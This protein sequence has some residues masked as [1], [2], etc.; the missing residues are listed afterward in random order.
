MLEVFA[1]GTDEALPIVRRLAVREMP[2]SA[3]PEDQLAD[4][5]IDSR[6]ITSAALTL[7][8]A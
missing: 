2:G 6:A 7:A 4:T 3:T 5:G 8:R 1:D